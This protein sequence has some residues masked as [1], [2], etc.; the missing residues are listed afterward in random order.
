MDRGFKLDRGKGLKV[1]KP[2]RAVCPKC[3]KRGLGQPKP[4]AYG[5]VP[6]LQRTCQYCGH[7][8]TQLCT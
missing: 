4:N 1:R 2:H 3:E 7:F 6:M 8:T 5:A